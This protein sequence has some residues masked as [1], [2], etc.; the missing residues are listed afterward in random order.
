MLIVLT[1]L[2]S[3]RVSQFDSCRGIAVRSR[4]GP[5][6]VACLM[7]P[8][9][10]AAQD[11]GQPREVAEKVVPMSLYE[12]LSLLVS[13]VGTLGTVY[14]GLRQ[15]RQA[16][17]TPATAHHAP[18]ASYWRRTATTRTVCPT[19]HHPWRGRVPGR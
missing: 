10:Q 15:L 1:G 5:R 13:S 6:K 8:P 9:C 11:C 18:V 19:A 7:R 17:P 4:G 14:I 12:A 16:A 3:Y 2:H